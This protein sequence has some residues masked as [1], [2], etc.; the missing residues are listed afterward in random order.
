MTLAEFN[1]LPIGSKVG[2]FRYVATKRK[3]LVV[4]EQQMTSSMEPGYKRAGY[5]EGVL[6]SKQ[7]EFATVKFDNLIPC[8]NGGKPSNTWQVYYDD[9]D[10]V[11]I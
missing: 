7:G 10:E 6:L 8:I 4:D 1:L 2:T 11:T 9:L 3:R 5:D